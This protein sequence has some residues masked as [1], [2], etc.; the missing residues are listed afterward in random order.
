MFKW[1]KYE[2]AE[3]QWFCPIDA[4]GKIVNAMRYDAD[5]FLLMWKP[6]TTFDVKTMGKEYT[7]RSRPRSRAREEYKDKVDREA[8]IKKARWGDEPG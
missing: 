2:D 7:P 4:Q 6:G 1:I 3:G 5:N 8:A